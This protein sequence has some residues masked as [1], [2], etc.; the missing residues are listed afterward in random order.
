MH[1]LELIRW[2]NAILQNDEA[3]S[4]EELVKHFIEGRLTQQ[5]ALKAVSQRNKCL[6]DIFYEISL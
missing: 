5:E 3:S 2:V 4:D 6:N 1:S